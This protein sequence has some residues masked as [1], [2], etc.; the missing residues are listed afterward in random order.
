MDFGAKGDGRQDDSKPVWS[1]FQG[2]GDKSCVCCEE[3]RNMLKLM[4]WYIWYLVYL[5]FILSGKDLRLWRHCVHKSFAFLFQKSLG[6]WLRQYMYACTPLN[7][8]QRQI[9]IDI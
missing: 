9:R 4:T 7:V 3:L 5:Y 1:G 8:I 6:W 2:K